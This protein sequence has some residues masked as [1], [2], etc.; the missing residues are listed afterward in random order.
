MKKSYHPSNDVWQ[1]HL[2]FTL[3]MTIFF[4]INL[5]ISKGDTNAVC[6]IPMS[7][8]FAPFIPLFIILSLANM[9]I[10]CYIIVLIVLWI[11]CMFY[12][13]AFQS[14]LEL[15]KRDFS[16]IKSKQIIVMMI[17]YVLVIGIISLG[18]SLRKDID[19][20]DIHTMNVIVY[21]TNEEPMTYS[22][23]D[24]QMIENYVNAMIINTKSYN[25]TKYNHD[26]IEELE[27]DGIDYHL[28]F[29]GHHKYL[30]KY[31]N[32]YCDYDGEKYLV[33]HYNVFTK[34]LKNDFIR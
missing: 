30:Y 23:T 1:F 15:K 20:D 24:K 22:T 31:K 2:K 21:Q 29:I 26:V 9:D 3:M 14:E 11:N 28:E 17:S 25:N 18:K 12:Y 5:M 10:G 33:Y 13:Y 8:I 32:G 7:I 19:E 6:W 34:E 16:F 27:K 4:F